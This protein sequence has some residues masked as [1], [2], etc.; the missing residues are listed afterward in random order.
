MSAHVRSARTDARMTERNSAGG[1]DGIRK[2][3]VVRAPP[4]RA[5]HTDAIGSDRC[6][7]AAFTLLTVLFRLLRP[8][9]STPVLLLV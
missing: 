4:L 6:S 2:E 3:G 5:S 8:A 7:A 9:D 1:E